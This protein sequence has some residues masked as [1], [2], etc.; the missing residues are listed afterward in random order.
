M[1]ITI[2]RAMCPNC[3]IN[4]HSKMGGVGCSSGNNITLAELSKCG[5]ICD[6]SEV[7]ELSN[8]E[9]SIDAES[10]KSSSVLQL[11]GCEDLNRSFSDPCGTGSSTCSGGHNRS[12]SVASH[13]HRFVLDFVTSYMGK[14]VYEIIETE[15]VYVSDLRD[16][17][18]VS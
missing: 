1:D 17:V 5:H 11:Q 2:A 4:N 10:S 12:P 7:S 9:T 6:I 16:I 13:S 3:N 15:R 18:Q 14:V 8:S